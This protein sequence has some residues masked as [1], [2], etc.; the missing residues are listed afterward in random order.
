MYIL[1]FIEGNLGNYSAAQAHASKAQRLARVSAKLKR[2]AQALHIEAKCWCILGN[3]KHTISLCS[4]GRDLL[5]LC[6]MSGG[7]LDHGLMIT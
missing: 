4:T 3:Y 6:G 7:R 5:A 1:A 2:E